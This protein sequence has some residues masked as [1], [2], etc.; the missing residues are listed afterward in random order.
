VLVP[1]AIRGDS[2]DRF[3]LGGPSFDVLKQQG[4]PRDDSNESYAEAVSKLT[5]A[6]TP[7]GRQA[8]E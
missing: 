5:V 7:T 2:R 6:L 8:G 3:D 4:P 1:T